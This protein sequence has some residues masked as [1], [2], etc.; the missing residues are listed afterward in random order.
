MDA[1]FGGNDDQVLIGR[2]DEDTWWQIVAKRLGVGP[3]AVDE[4]RRDLAAREVWDDRLVQS[5]RRARSMARVGIV[6]NAWPSMRTRMADR[7]LLDVADEL[8]LSC[9]VG[10]AKP[11]VRIFE[12]ALEHL[13]TTPQ[14]VL[15][16]DDQAGHVEVAV[17]LGMAGHVHVG[18]ADTIARIDRFLSAPPHP[19]PRHRQ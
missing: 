2:V 8:V 11:A 1:L 18:S 12:I 10:C 3:A 4:I 5:L 16:V 7:G 14:D 15:F 19:E 9:E 17:S 13:A 6:S